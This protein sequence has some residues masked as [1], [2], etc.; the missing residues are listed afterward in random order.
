LN[1]LATVDALLALAPGS[2]QIVSEDD[3]FGT[4]H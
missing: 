4:E 1:S 3:R 2:P